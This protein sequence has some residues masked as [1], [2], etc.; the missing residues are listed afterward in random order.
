MEKNIQ[1]NNSYKKSPNNEKTNLIHNVIK[2]YDE[3]KKTIK[4]ALITAIILL[5]ALAWNDVIE[6][7]SMIMWKEKRNSLIGKIHYAFLITFIVLAFQIFFFP[8]ENLIT[9]NSI[10]KI[11]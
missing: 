2:T 5:V 7:I 3:Y 9:E 11:N 6:D 1:N 8:K 10:T 4:D